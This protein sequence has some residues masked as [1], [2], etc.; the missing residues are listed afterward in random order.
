MRYLTVAADYTQSCL[1][2][3]FEGPMEPETLGLPQILCD[4]LRKWND[5][6]RKVIPLSEEDR[7][8]ATVV[9][10]IRRLD[11]QGQWLA[12]WVAETLEPEVKV[13]YYSEGCL[14]YL[15]P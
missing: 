11:E 15:S 4:E 6:Y 9:Q 5:Q 12:E 13:R 7:E 14:K 3:D 10:L 2:D 8:R 1:R